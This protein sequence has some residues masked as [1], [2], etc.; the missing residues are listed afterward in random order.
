MTMSSMIN[1]ADGR[2]PREDVEFLARSAHR[3][4]VLGRLAD[5]PHERVELREAT[6]ASSPTLG[7]VL[8]DFEGRRWVVRQGHRYELTPLGEFVADRFED[9]LDAMTTERKLRDVWRWLPRE[10]E[11][12]SVEL[13]ADAVVSYPGPR[14]PYEPVE[15]VTHLIERTDA[16]FGFGTTVF[17]TINVEAV[18]EGVLDDMTYEYIYSP[19][20]LEATVACAP[21]RVAAAAARDNCTILVH[22]ALPD[23][24][25]CG[26]GIFDDCMGI[27]CHDS[28]TGMLEAIVDTESAA[29]REWAVS[30]YDRYRAEARPLDPKEAEALVSSHLAS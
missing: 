11:G 2:S 6:G 8:G 29:A 5:R 20:V 12:F 27:C 25:R 10:M 26:L 9:L 16:M 23:E 17:K 22:D 3:V 1:D 21:E 13:F 4:G 19:D 14:Y 15:R 28:A 24:D 18:C 7:R 30:V